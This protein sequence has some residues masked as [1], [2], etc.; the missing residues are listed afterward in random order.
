MRC[1]L[2]CK[3]CQ[4]VWSCRAISEPDVGIWA[5]PDDRDEASAACPE[6]GCEDYENIDAE[7]DDYD[8]FNE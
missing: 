2:K 4:H 8:A 7:Y 6:C 3:S 5:M 1:I